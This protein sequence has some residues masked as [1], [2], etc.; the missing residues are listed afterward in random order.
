VTWQTFYVVFTDG[1]VDV[2]GYDMT[3]NRAKKSAC[4]EVAAGRVV[5]VR[6]DFVEVRNNK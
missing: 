3:P 2:S 5:G 6:G 1:V 4:E